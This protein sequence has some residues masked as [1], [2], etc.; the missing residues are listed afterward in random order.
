MARAVDRGA[1]PAY[2]SCLM[3]PKV[4]TEVLTKHCHCTRENDV[5][6]SQED[7]TLSLYVQAGEST[8]T[9]RGA[10]TITFDGEVV[11]AS[12]KEGDWI[13]MREDVCAVHSFKQ[14]RP[15]GYA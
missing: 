4:L 6:T 5:F 10:T 1:K 2:S 3:T 8:L 13:F 11:V 9:I 7:V 14:R 15:V 12:S